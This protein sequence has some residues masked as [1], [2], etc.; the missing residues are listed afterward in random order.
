M[1]CT[2]S[3]FQAGD[4]VPILPS[5]MVMDHLGGW[6]G[7]FHTCGCMRLV[8]ITP[9]LALLRDAAP[10]ESAKAEP[11][12]GITHISLAQTTTHEAAPGDALVSWQ[13]SSMDVLKSVPWREFWSS[14]GVPATVVAFATSC[15]GHPPF[16]PSSTGSSNV[17]GLVGLPV[18]PCVMG[19]VGG[20][21]VGALANSVILSFEEKHK[22]DEQARTKSFQG[23]AVCGVLQEE[24]G[25][26]PSAKQGKKHCH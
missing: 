8:L 14:R 7:L 4:V 5:P 2:I 25:T 18:L 15:L 26:C 19:A 23:V 24:A 3:V 6:R 13:E 20:L 16:V 10:P 22:E 11:P 17:K 9:S 1:P 12:N 21:V